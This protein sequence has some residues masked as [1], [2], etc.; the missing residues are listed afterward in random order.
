[1]DRDVKE[2]YESYKLK[3]DLKAKSFEDILQRNS[4]KD[5]NWFFR[6]YVEQRNNIDFKIKKVKKNEDSI[7]V[8]IKN[9]TGSKVPI[10][11]FGLQKDSVVSKY[12][13]SDIDSTRTVTI[14]NNDESRLVLNYDKKIPEVNQRDNWKSTNG[15]FSSNKKFQ[16]RFFKDVENPYYN[17][18][19]WVPEFSFNVNNG[20][21]L[22]ISLN[23]K[24]F[25]NRKFTFSIKPK[26]SGRENAL[27]GSLGFTK[28][29][30]YNEGK[31]N[32]LSYSLGYGNG[33]FAENSRVS[34][35]TPS[36]R[37]S[38]RPENF[39]S[40]RR[41]FLFARIRNVFRNIDP[42]VQDL[43]DTEPDFSVFNV[44]YGDVNNN[45]LKYRRWVIDAQVADKFTKVSF[46]WEHRTLYFTNRQLN[47]R[48]YAGKFITNTSGSDF[49][50]FALDR[51]TDYL[52]DL[53]YLNNAPGATG[54]SSQQFILAEGGFKSIFDDRFADDF[55]LTGNLSFNLWRWIE[56]YGDVG[57]IKDRGESVRFR[58]DSGVR[59][60]LVTDFFELYFPV[61]SNNGYEIAQPNYGDRIRF[62]ITISPKT[63]T[64]LFTRKWF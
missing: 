24:T 16:L 44:R 7:T 30:F 3:P 29:H 19:F 64:G 47:L 55:I 43:I 59:L 25:N 28:R 62:V 2:F 49:F 20:I 18:L 35:F 22:G 13:F 48:V 10:S 15:F 33:F 23:N 60:N 1:M 57:A 6:E 4:T 8:Q 41:Q 54:L 50:S 38:W 63:L 45:I 42:S 26:Y 40:N 5:I 36:F 53:G 27:I 14:P 51:P 32:Q 17:Q 34:T 61:Y 39:L 21:S 46:E 11:L 56:V 37:L 58:Y 12:W 9:K 52:F 31:L